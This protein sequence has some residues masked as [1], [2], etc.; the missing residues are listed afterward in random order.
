MVED[1]ESTLHPHG[2]VQPAPVRSRLRE[3]AILSPVTDDATEEIRLD[4]NETIIGRSAEATVTISAPDI[5]RRHVRIFRA[6]SDFI[7]E[8]LGSSNGTFVDSVEILTC[9]LRNGDMVQIGNHVYYF[10]RMLVPEGGGTYS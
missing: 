8:D 1:F 6:G 7:I 10:D 4:P 9:A 3:V 5:S 2:D